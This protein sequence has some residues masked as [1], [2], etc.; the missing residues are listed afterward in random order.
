MTRSTKQSCLYDNTNGDTHTMMAVLEL[1]T[2]DTWQPKDMWGHFARLL[3]NTDFILIL[4]HL[5]EA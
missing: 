5:L 1:L 3:I 4:N 2:G